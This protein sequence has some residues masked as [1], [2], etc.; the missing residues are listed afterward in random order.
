[1]LTDVSTKSEELSSNVV[2]TEMD[3]KDA[4][5]V[6]EEASPASDVVVKERE[7]LLGKIVKDGWVT[8]ATRSEEFTADAETGPTP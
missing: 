8:P 2:S 3:G 5:E 1:M 7:V 4:K 6:V